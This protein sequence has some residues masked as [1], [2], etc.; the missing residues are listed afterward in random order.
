[1]NWRTFLS[2]LAVTGALLTA[3]AA[4]ATSSHDDAGVPKDN[5]RN[6]TNELKKQRGNSET[7]K[8]DHAREDHSNGTGQNLQKKKSRLKYRDPFECGC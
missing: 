5:T 8:D 1:M 7:Y 6:E 4:A 2:A 3:P